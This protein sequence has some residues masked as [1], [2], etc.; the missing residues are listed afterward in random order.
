VAGG[1]LVC[2]EDKDDD[3]LGLDVVFDYELFMK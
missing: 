3:G 2:N 1:L